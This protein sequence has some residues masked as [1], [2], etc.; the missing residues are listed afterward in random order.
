VRFAHHRT[1]GTRRDAD[2]EKL[3]A[4]SF[5]GWHRTITMM[6]LRKVLNE[7]QVKKAGEV[8]TR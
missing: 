1:P 3:E 2:R 7:A 6:G 8:E 4:E 5:E